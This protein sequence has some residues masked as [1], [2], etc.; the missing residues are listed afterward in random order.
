MAGAPLQPRSHRPAASQHPDPAGRRSSDGRVVRQ[1]WVFHLFL[2]LDSHGPRG[3]G[4]PRPTG[5]YID[6]SKKLPPGME[7]K[8]KAEQNSLTQAEEEDRSVQAYCADSCRQRMRLTLL[9][10]AGWSWPR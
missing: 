7:G 3:A 10:W 8:A 6:L 1:V 5:R 9:H 2:C 4:G